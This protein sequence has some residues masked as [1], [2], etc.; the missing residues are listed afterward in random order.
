MFLGKE[1]KRVVNREEEMKKKIGGLV[2]LFAICLSGCAG[3]EKFRKEKGKP[4]LSSPTQASTPLGAPISILVK[5]KVSDYRTLNTFKKK[6]SEIRG[7]RNIYQKRFSVAEDSELEVR[8]IGST[9]KFADEII[10]HIH[11]PHLNLEITGFDQTSIT[12]NITPLPT[13]PFE[14]EGY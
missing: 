9:E 12:L 8:Y 3:V 4:E 13:T 1:N 7:V 2:L 5:V 6:L 14:E 11:L 10:N